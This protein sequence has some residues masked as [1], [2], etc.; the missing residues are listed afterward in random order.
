MR[1]DAVMVIGTRTSPAAAG[2]QVNPDETRA[3]R[4]LAEVGIRVVTIRD[5]PRFEFDIPA[6]VEESGGAG[7]ARPRA[8]VFS[9]GNP[10]EKAPG[11]PRSAAHLDLTPFI[12]GPDLCEGVAGNVLIYRDDDHLTATYATTLEQ[13]LHRALRARAEW[14]FAAPLNGPPVRQ[15]F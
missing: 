14:L 4:Q 8:D 1:P 10:V 3:W 5:N 15:R 6:C 9:P 13:P 12:C 2:D 11:A 7:C